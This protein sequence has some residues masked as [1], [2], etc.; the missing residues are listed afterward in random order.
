MVR[1]KKNLTWCLLLLKSS[2]FVGRKLQRIHGLSPQL[3]SATES[4]GEGVYLHQLSAA[5]PRGICT[6]V[7]G[8]SSTI[9]AAERTWT[10]RRWQTALK[11]WRKK[12]E[13]FLYLEENSRELPMRRKT[14]KRMLL[15]SVEE[16]F[17]YD[18]NWRNL[19]PIFGNK[20]KKRVFPQFKFPINV[21]IYIKR[22][23]AL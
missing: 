4:V 3:L 22:F 20:I 23:I 13:E 15:K 21:L 17:D 12:I 16:L 1:S 19:I 5:I 8:K 9:P 6:S 2:L 11:I 10:I 7:G 18:L 14:P